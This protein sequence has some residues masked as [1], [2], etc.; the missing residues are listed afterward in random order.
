VATLAIV[1]PVAGNGRARRVWQRVRAAVEDLR[2]CEWVVT[3]GIGHARELAARAAARGYERVVAVGGDGTVFEVANG[4]AKTPTALG[5]I[6]AGTGNDSARNFGIPGDPFAA[7]RVATRGVDVPIDLGEIRRAQTST[8]FVS[9]AGFGFDAE[10]AWRVNRASRGWGKALGGTRPYLAGVLQT[11]WQ[12]R[13]PPMRL[14]VDQRLVVRRMFMV[15]VANSPSYGGGM[16]IAPQAV[17]DDGLLDVCL[18]RDVSRL[19]VLRLV[20]RIYSGGHVSHP[21]VELVRCRELTADADH[22]VR[23]H[24]DGELVGELPVRVGIVPGGLRCVTGSASR[25]PP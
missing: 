17:P 2:A 18:V 14:S 11:L 16:R 4:L 24:A 7:A 12:Y 15:A 8:Y 22:R 13:S 6:P 23:C 5:I 1:N 21:A 9:V 19:D 20:P 3:E 25:S 10:V